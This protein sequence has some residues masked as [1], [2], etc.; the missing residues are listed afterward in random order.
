MK[1]CGGCNPEIDRG[2]LVKHVQALSRG[3]GD[4]VAFVG[5]A[6]EGDLLLQVNGCPRACLEEDGPGPGG[7]GKTISVQGAR[8]DLE[9][10]PEETLHLVVWQR[11]KTIWSAKS[12]RHAGARGM[13]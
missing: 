12:E 5:H 11:I 9:A 13:G 4:A 7:A 1:Y 6:A 3:E 8:V 2:R 10:V